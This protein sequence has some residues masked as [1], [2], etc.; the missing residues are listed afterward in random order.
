MK[1]KE[2]VLDMDGTLPNFVEKTLEISV[3]P[4]DTKSAIKTSHILEDLDKQEQPI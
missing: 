4:S 3:N 2:L 1:P